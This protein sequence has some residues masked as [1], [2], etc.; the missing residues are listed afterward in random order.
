MA[1]RPLVLAIFLLAAAPASAGPIPEDIGGR[2]ADGFAVPAAGAF[3]V[4]ARETA[5]RA[6]ALCAQPDGAALDAARA[7]FAGLVEAWARVSVLRFGPLQAQNRFE[8]AFFWPDPRGVIVRQVQALL[9][10]GDESALEPEALAG[11]SV[12]LQGLPAL[13]FVLYGSGSEELEAGTTGGYRCRYG[14]AIAGNLAAIAEILTAEWTSSPFRQSFVAP[15]QD[16]DPYRSNK[17]VAAETVKALGTGLQFVRA[18]ELLPALGESAEEAK[19]R[20]APLWR[21]GLTF[22][23]VGAQIDGLDALLEAAGF[24]ETGEA[25]ART[26]VDGIRFDLVHAREAIAA[27]VA[28]A[29]HAFADPQ[30]RERIRYVTVALNSA[31]AALGERLSAALGLT[32]GFNALDGD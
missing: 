12:A 3:E 4:A 11:K 9:A 28:P 29:E 21:S 7:G 1:F 13:E 23:L 17:E 15:A 24:H 14:A 30:D 32:M 16:G 10:A 19:G 2:I 6:G 22:A 31:N 5:R 20:R 25:A 18:A 27:I 26:A 8:R